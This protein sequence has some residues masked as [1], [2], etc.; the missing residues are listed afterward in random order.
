MRRVILAIVGTVAGLVVLLSF[1]THS[2][3][4]AATPPAA[5]SGTSGQAS[6]AAAAPSASSSSRASTSSSASGSPSSIAGAAKTVTGTASDTMYGPVQVQI[7]VKNGKVTAAQA[8]QYPQDSPRD[9][10]INSY[11]IPVLNQEAVSASSAS[12]DAVSGATYTSG[13]YVTSL[14]S[15]LDKA[16]V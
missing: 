10:Q 15:A 8:V 6:A 9:Q 1:K 2:T 12:I 4:A 3:S 11:A 13:G 16:G 7:T 5:I 14:Q